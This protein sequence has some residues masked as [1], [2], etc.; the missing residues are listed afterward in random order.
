MVSEHTLERIRS[1]FEQFQETTGLA[2]WGLDPVGWNYNG[3]QQTDD[4]DIHLL[5]GNSERAYF[6]ILPEP[7]ASMERLQS[8]IHRRMVD[9]GLIPE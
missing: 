1:A 8:Q 9:A 7:S 5:R 4:V 3:N 2:G 6:T